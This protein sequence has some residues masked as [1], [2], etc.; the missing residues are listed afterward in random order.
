MLLRQNRLN[1]QLDGPSLW[2]VILYSITSPDFD[3]D[4]DLPM[5]TS[6]ALPVFMAFRFLDHDGFYTST[7]YHPNISPNLLITAYHPI[8]LNSGLH[9]SLQRHGKGLCF[10]CR[11]TN[12]SKYC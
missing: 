8:F 11:S 12:L 6:L 9:A 2:Q 3:V 5:T 10:F 1:K 7:P 4:K